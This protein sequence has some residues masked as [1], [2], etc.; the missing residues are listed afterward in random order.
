MSDPKER[1]ILFSSPMVR[2]I[3]DGRKIQTRRA[4]KHQRE[5]Y[6]NLGDGVSLYDFQSG[7]PISC[8]YGQPG[9]LLWV[10]ETFCKSPDGPI[11]KATE[12]E[13]GI[14]EPGDS[15][16]WT[17]SIY[18]PKRYARIW[19]EINDVRVDRLQD[20][21]GPDIEAEGIIESCCDGRECC[22]RGAYVDPFD[23]EPI[24]DP[25]AE[26]TK[27]W[28]SING[29]GSWDKNPWVWVIEFIPVGAGDEL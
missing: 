13:A 16:K 25:I 19:L 28:E 9:D 1:P 22:C 29:V 18:M 4:V 12:R 3:L 5:S 20:I 11:Y 6:D 27:L 14:L 7:L 15:I 23:G 2:A 17:P 24:D 26:F 10:R 21:G 8:P